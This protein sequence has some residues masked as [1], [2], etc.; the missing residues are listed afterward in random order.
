MELTHATVVN[1][2]LETD[3]INQINILTVHI[4]QLITQ[5]QQLQQQNNTL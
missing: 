2:V 3:I 5:L 4:Q 1:D